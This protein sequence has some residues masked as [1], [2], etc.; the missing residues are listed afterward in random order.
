MEGAHF[1]LCHSFH[2]YWVTH[3]QAHMSDIAFKTQSLFAIQNGSVKLVSSGNNTAQSKSFAR[4]NSNKSSARAVEPETLSSQTRDTHHKSSYQSLKS[5]M[6]MAVNTTP[7]TLT[8]TNVPS[9]SSTLSLLGSQSCMQNLPL[10]VALN[11]DL[12]A[13]SAQRLCRLSSHFYR[14]RQRQQ[15]PAVKTTMPKPAL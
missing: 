3:S 6:V 10:Q 9:S 7:S 14:H 15:H 12:S 2:K 5:P 1:S 8:W 11:I 13:L 4:C